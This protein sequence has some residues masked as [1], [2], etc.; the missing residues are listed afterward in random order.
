MMAT[1]RPETEVCPACG[2]RGACRIHAY[3][4]RF[5]VDFVNGTQVT[6]V[7]RIMRVRCSCGN[8]H[9]ILPDPVIPYRFHSLFFIL[10]VLTEYFRRKNV[11]RLC[12]KYL[13]SVSQLYRWKKVFELHRHEWLGVLKSS[14]STPT[15]FITELLRFSPFKDFAWSFFNLTAV[16][17]LQS[18]RNPA[19]LR[20][21][22][23]PP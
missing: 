13:I 14:T 7:L 21:N 12:E 9:A 17:F 10:C 23:S 15:S 6:S 22:T 11:L 1:F 20:R 19:G 2:L 8:T 16:S 18:H 3:Y 4:N 5:I